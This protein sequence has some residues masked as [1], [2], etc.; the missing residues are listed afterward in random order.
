MAGR[1]E[2]DTTAAW[3]VEAV[4]CKGGEGVGG[5]STEGFW[6]GGGVSSGSSKLTVFVG[7][8]ERTEG[9]QSMFPGSDVETIATI[10]GMHHMKSGEETEGC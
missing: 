7:R 9:F 4:I 8:R 5:A 6:G 1:R 3:C 10:R 2:V